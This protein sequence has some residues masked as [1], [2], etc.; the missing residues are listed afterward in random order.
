VFDHLKAVVQTICQRLQLADAGGSSAAVGGSTY[1][2][3]VWPG[4]PLQ[5]E[6]LGLRDALRQH[7][8]E[9]RARVEAYNQAHGVPAELDEVVFYLG[10]CV[11]ERGREEQDD[12]DGQHDE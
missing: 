7:C 9:L 4:H 3:D 11:F 6:V 5:A 8:G 12:E 1:G 2:F 10:Q